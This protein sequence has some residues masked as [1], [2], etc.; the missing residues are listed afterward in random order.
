MKDKHHDELY[1]RAVR[2]NA[3]QAIQWACSESRQAQQRAMHSR[4]HLQIAGMWVSQMESRLEHAQLELQNA[5]DVLERL[6]WETQR[7]TR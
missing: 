7:T 3:E 4:Q 2:Q 1:A 6:L 5:H